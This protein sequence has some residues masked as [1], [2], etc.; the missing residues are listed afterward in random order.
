LK[1]VDV[2]REFKIMYMC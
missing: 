1:S 2:V